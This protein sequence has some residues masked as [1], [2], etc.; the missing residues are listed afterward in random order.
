MQYEY[1]ATADKCPLPLVKTRVMLKKLEQGDCLRVLIADHG[2]KS[3]LPRYLT[4]VGYAFQQQN[5][6]NSVVEILIHYR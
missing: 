1:D 3:D 6:D 5:I 4:K 2:T